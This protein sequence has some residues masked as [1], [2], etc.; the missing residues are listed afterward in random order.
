VN[1]ARLRRALRRGV[2]AAASLRAAVWMLLWFIAIVFV[3]TLY[4]ASEGLYA[5]QEQ[6]YYAWWTPPVSRWYAPETAD[7]LSRALRWL[8]VPL[9]G[10][11]LTMAALGVNLTLRLVRHLR[12]GWRDVGAVLMHAGILLLLA[13][14]ALT[15]SM[16]EEGTLSL[17][18]GDASAAAPS[19][20]RWEIALWTGDGTADETT[21]HATDSL[22]AGDTLRFDEIDLTLLVRTWHPDARAF[23][24]PVPE[25]A[26]APLNVAGITRIEPG[27]GA[28]DPAAHIPA[29]RLSARRGD[30]T[31]QE[32]ILTGGDP[33]P[34]VLTLEGRPWQLQLRRRPIPLPVE[35]TLL[36][37]Q[38][39]YEPNSRISR[40]Y[41]SRIRVRTGELERETLV[42]MNRPFR[43]GAYTLFQS[44]YGVTEDGR[45]LSVFAV[46]HNRVLWAPYLATWITAAGMLLHGLLRR[47][48]PP[49]RVEAAP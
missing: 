27:P 25:G 14:A 20:A 35:V 40:R 36:D 41:A 43:Q 39:A 1:T 13:G 23:L 44:S 29:A 28:G 31:P 17:A 8:R 32:L 5:A 11:A 6:F 15:R 33:L 3:G 48:P 24:D 34:L 7:A 37:F 46:T 21:A 9:P 19:R 38:K 26:A 49:T 18:V 42:E 45:D 2:D 30:L 4:Q 47:R 16:A 22:A 12:G 10:G